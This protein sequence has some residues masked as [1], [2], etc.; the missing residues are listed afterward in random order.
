MTASPQPRHPL[1][2]EALAPQR[3]RISNGWLACDLMN[4]VWLPC[5]GLMGWSSWR[6]RC[7]CAATAIGVSS[8]MPGT[9]PLIT[10]SS[11]CRC[12][13]WDGPAAEAG[14]LSVLLVQRFQLGTSELRLD[15]RFRADCPWLELIASVDWRQRHELLRLELDLAKGAVRFAADTSGG[16]IERPAQPRTAREQERWEV[17]VVSW[18]ASQSAAPGGGLAVLLEGAQGVDAVVDRLGVSLLGGAHL[19]GSRG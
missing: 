14:P 8:G 19:A 17:P 5:R 10:V 9:S 6:D 18:L 11:R 13:P 1:V 12:T 4:R 3:W 2:V 15:L 16:V 7:G